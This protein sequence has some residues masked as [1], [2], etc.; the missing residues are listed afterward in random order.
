LARRKSRKG[1]QAITRLFKAIGNRHVSYPP[2][3][4][5]C[6]ALLLD[7]VRRVRVHHGMVVRRNLIVKPLGCVSKQI[8]EL[9]DCT[10]LRRHIGP[11][12]RQRSIKAGATV[13]NQ[14]LGLP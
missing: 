14:E 2:F 6:L 5:E 12:R 4:Q 3:A 7:F 13:D 10:T 9:V 11:D 8:P 1:E